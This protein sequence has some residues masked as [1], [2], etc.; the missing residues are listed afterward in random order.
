ME[1][2]PILVVADADAAIDFYTR[3]FD[4]E[5]EKRRGEDRVKY[6]V[7]LMQNQRIALKDTDEIDTVANPTGVIL[8]VVTAAPDAVQQSA[9]NAGAEV[10]EPVANQSYGARAGRIRDPFGHQWILTTRAQ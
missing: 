7:I 10:I 3:V 8:E 4:A 5:L 2:I 6:A 1:I 9:L